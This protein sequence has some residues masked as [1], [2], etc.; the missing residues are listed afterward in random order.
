MPDVPVVAPP[1]A[2]AAPA[3]PSAPSAP[4]SPHVSL[5]PETSRPPVE[6]PAAKPE[7]A[8]PELKF[9][10]G[11]E[12]EEAP[13]PVGEGEVD[14]AKP[15]DPALEELLKNSPEQLKQAKAAWYDNRN[16]KASGFKNAQE[17]KAHVESLNKLAT[18]LGRVDGLKGLA[19]VEA[20]AKEWHATE[21]AF[22]RGDENVV[23]QWAEELTPEAM[24]KLTNAWDA[25]MLAKNPQGWSHQKAQLFMSELR[26]QNSQGRSILT[27]LNQLLNALPKDSAERGLLVEIGQQINELDEISRKAPEVAAVKT[28]ERESRIAQREKG[29]TIK[30]AEIKILP[31]ISSAAQKAAKV[32]LNGRALGPEA[33]RTFTEE[34]QREFL[35]LSSSKENIEFSRNFLD[36]LNADDKEGYERLSRANIAKLMPT[37]AKNINRK[38]QGF[39]SQEMKDRAAEGASRVETAAGGTQAGAK[40][41][42]TGKMIQGGPDPAVVDWPHMRVVAGSNKGAEDMFFDH[43]FFVKGDSK[44]EYFW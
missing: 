37:A 1:A 10:F 8:E 33:L 23:K 16:W 4:P 24:T 36:Y 9:D 41:R 22:R 11:F 40:M 27:N 42:Y 5:K 31:Q 29:I 17:L 32:V 6:V 7:G 15:F 19:A 44:N 35:R 12:G 2:P 25:Q 43:R 21:E 3:A 38:Y 34:I 30:E 13:Q 18:S 28:D 14:Y 26:A 20:E 39:T